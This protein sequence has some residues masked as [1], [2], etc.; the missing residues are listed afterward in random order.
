MTDGTIS[1]RSS[2]SSA[3]FGR[4]IAS[5]IEELPQTVD[6]TIQ[7]LGRASGEPV[8]VTKRAQGVWCVAVDDL[9]LRHGNQSQ[10]AN[11]LRQDTQQTRAWSN[12][13]GSKEK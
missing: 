5:V 1:A 11:V 7:F 4:Y 3:A 10:T 2:A 13:Q 9:R 8:N 6:E 12:P